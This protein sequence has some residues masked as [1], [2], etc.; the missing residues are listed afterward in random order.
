MSN[1]LNVATLTVTVQGQEYVY[2]QIKIVSKHAPLQEVTV[3]SL[4]LGKVDLSAGG[5]ILDDGILRVCR[6]PGY[7]HILSGRNKVLEAINTGKDVV[8]ARMVSKAALGRTMVP[9]KTLSP[10]EIAQRLA[11][12]DRWKVQKSQPARSNEHHHQ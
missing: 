11:G 3:A 5:V 7:V 4:R 8:M 9:P 12:N 10:E 1:S 2:D 6:L